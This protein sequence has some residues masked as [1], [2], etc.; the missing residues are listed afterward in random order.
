MLLKNI[1]E[2]CIGLQPDSHRQCSPYRSPS[3][4]R[5]ATTMAVWPSVRT[6]VRS[7]AA[8]RCVPQ[9]SRTWV[10]LGGPQWRAT[11]MTGGREYLVICSS[12]HDGSTHPHI[13]SSFSHHS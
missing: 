2:I 5:H 9:V 10:Y 13:H 8:A 1:K 6:R 4:S 3:V 7:T 11:Q 12:L